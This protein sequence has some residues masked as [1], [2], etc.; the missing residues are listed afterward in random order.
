MSWKDDVY[1]VLERDP[2]PKSFKE[3]LLFSPGLHAILLHRISHRLY[4][5]GQYLLARAINYF[6]RILT[7]ADIHPGAKIGK[8][9][10]IDHATGVVIG[11]TAE[12]GDNVCIF[13]GVTLGGVS[14]EKGK[15][16][17]TIGNNVVIGANAT[18]LG[19]IKIGDNVKIGAGSVVV[20]DVPP[21]ST[22]VGVPGK[23]VKK[24]GMTKIDL[25][26]DLL[27]DPVVDAFMNISNS[28][29]ELEHRVAE[30]ERLVR[31]EK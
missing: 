18:I 30:L 28:I 11:E 3:A 16:H 20:K 19:N 12:I 27:P 14:T 17:P 15:R 9:F 2:A 23:V 26:H 29:A 13:Q 1:T 21:N 31:K 6:A 10:F 22:V 5:K 7:G 8:G 4:L 24:D 25:R